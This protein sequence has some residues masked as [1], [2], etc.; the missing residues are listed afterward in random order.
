MSTSHCIVSSWYQ[1]GLYYPIQVY[2]T[3]MRRR[4]NAVGHC[5]PF[6]DNTLINDSSNTPQESITRC[7]RIAPRMEMG[8]CRN[9]TMTSR[10][11]RFPT[12]IPLHVMALI[13]IKTQ[14]SCIIVRFVLSIFH[15]RHTTHLPHKC[16]G[17]PEQPQD[18]DC[19]YISPMVK[20]H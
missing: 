5:R 20:L 1:W 19:R 6:L 15:K 14:S 10:R 4:T 9:T 17:T 12:T 2:L 7:S 8:S 18:K 13:F 11:Y 16:N 3:C